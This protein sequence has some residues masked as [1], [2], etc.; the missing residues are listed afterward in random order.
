MERVIE[1][2]GYTHQQELKMFILKTLRENAPNRVG[3]HL[4]AKFGTN[5]CQHEVRMARPVLDEVVNDL[6]DLG[7]VYARKDR[8]GLYLELAK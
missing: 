7:V 8:T 5:G 2:F 6:V 3:V 1:K 4:F